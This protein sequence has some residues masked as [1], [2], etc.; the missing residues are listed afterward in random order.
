[1]LRQD[2]IRSL[3][4][5]V[6]SGHLVDSENV[7]KDSSSILLVV[8]EQTRAFNETNVNIMKAII[9][10]FI[11]VCE[12]N[13]SKECSLSKW[14][15]RDGGAVCVKKISDR[16]LSGL[17]QNL[18]TALCVVSLPSSLV[19]AAFEN[20]KSVKSPVAHEEFLKWFLTFCRDFGAESLGP[21][22][23]EIVPHLIEVS[24]AY[25]LCPLIL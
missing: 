8:R 15:V 25:T 11:A 22:I 20:L 23:S 10:L 19:L 16:K 13:E 4:A 18:L 5:F 7:E 9:Q 17:C 1:L 3:T 21:E 12:F 14:A 2:A 6:E 24:S